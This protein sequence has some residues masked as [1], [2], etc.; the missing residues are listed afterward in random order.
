MPFLGLRSPRKRSI[1]SVCEHFE[2]KHD[3]KITFIVNSQVVLEVVYKEGFLGRRW[4]RNR[5]LLIVNE[6]FENESN[7]KITFIDDFTL[8]FIPYFLRILAILGW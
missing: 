2:G 4:S 7:A 6:D 1:P 5:S 8:Y 3:A